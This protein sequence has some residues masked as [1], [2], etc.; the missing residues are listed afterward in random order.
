MRVAFVGNMNQHAFVA[1]RHLRA[2]GVS[3]ELVMHGADAPEF[4]PSYDTFDL[5]YMDYV[6]TVP[7]GEATHFSAHTAEAVR[8]VLEGYDAIVAEGPIPA[9]LHRAGLRARL[10]LPYGADVSELPHLRF[11]RPSRGALASLPLFPLAQRAGLREAHFIGGTLSAEVR[12]GLDTWGVRA[13]RRPFP[14]IPMW[15][16]EMGP[17]AIELVFRRSAWVHEVDVLRRRSDVILFHHGAPPMGAR[18]EPDGLAPALVEALAAVRRDHP[19]VGVALVILEAAT[20]ADVALERAEELGLR[21]HVLVLPPLAR[22][23]LLVAL[24]GCDIMVGSGEGTLAEG[25]VAIDGLAANKRVLVFGA[26]EDA[27]LP[28]V[29]VGSAEAVARAVGD[30]IASPASAKAAS[31]AGRAFYERE[32]RDAGLRGLEEALGISR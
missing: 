31:A 5:G 24:A 27:E 23:E 1:V 16:A 4:H 3:A 10:I 32:V 25:G 12:E 21:E 18:G 26:P 19:D 14:R 9:F 30:Y 20:G 6:R 17:D 7:W 2:R 15:D 28:I 29:G 22:K 11:R 8:A 13:A